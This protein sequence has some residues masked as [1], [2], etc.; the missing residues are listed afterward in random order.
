MS[1]ERRY[2]EEE[3]AAIFEQAV[4]AEEAAPR[5]PSHGEGLTLAELQHVG[6]EAG[7]APGAVARAAAAMDRSNPPPPP[8]RLFGLPISVTRTAYLPDSLTDAE[9]DRLVVDLRE[10]FQATGTV[11]RDGALREWR[12]G[13]LHALVEPTASGHR[14]RLSTRKG[15]A[16]ESIALSIGA[17][18]MATVFFVLLTTLSEPSLGMTVIMAL[19]LAVGL[20]GAG[21]TA[22]RLPH[23]AKK[24]G[25]QMDALAVRAVERM[26][27]PPAADT[28]AAT[29]RAREA[30]PAGRL[31]PGV[32]DKPADVRQNRSER[33]T[34]T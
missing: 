4:R 26:S 22:L 32:L 30:A 7:I 17:L 6:R 16:Q 2:T 29:E 3:I 21:L 1:T 13:N 14:L 8:V 19:F 20:G 11:R 5:T 34:R 31:D 28:D 23:W 18:A 15:N 33:R 12:N 9:W 10:T 25:R 24:R 27:A